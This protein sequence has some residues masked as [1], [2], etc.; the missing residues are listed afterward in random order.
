M[1]NFFKLSFSFLLLLAV[2]GCGFHLRGH[3]PLPE[4]L[5]VLHL[6]TNSPYSDFTKQLKSFLTSAKVVLV[7]TSQAAP[8]TLQILS[9]RSSQQLASVSASGQ[10]NAYSLLYTVTYVL[11]DRQGQ[12]IQA[13]QT[14]STSR[15]YSVTSNQVLGDTNV[16]N[17]L[18]AQMQRDVIYQMLNRLSSPRTVQMLA[19]KINSTP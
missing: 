9:E 12:P 14:V 3:Q 8:L 13:P 10:T 19:A 15:S 17:I 2:T 7:D 1:L 18:I 6:Q 11:L 5:K 16:Q 4:E